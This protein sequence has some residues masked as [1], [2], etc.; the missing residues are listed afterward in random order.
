M[1]FNNGAADPESHAGAVSLCG[2]KG[3]KDLVRVLWREPHACIGDRDQH[4]TIL[5]ALRLD[6]QPACPISMLHRVDAVYDE[7]HQHLLQFH[8]ISYHLRKVRCEFGPN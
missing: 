2:K 7:I 8:T 6:D 4:L 5:T 3:I 1:R